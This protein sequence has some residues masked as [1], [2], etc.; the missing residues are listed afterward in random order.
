MALVAAFVQYK[1]PARPGFC[2]NI[3]DILSNLSNIASS[4]N[5]FLQI[6]PQNI[7]LKD[8]KM[9]TKMTDKIAKITWRRIAKDAADRTR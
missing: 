2:E 8:T 7:Q 9:D 1:A 5:G 3:S 6:L 4:E